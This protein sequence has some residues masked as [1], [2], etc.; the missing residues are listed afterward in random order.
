MMPTRVRSAGLEDEVD[1]LRVGAVNIYRIPDIAHIAWP[2]QALFVSLAGDKLAQAAKR[3][4][5]GM[6]D[7]SSGALILSFNVYLIETPEVVVL[8]DAGIGNDKERLDRPAWH[9]RSGRFLETLH[10]LGFAPDRIDL[11]VNTHLHA[12]H[13]GWNTVLADGIWRPTFPRARYVTSDVELAHWRG[14]HDADPSK[15][16][17][18][19]SFAD[20]VLPLIEAGRL[21]AVPSSTALAPGLSLAPVP[22]HSPGMVA[23][24]LTTPEAEILFLADAIHHPVQ[25]AD[26]ALCSNFCFD[27]ARA[28]ATR[29]R[30]LAECA[31]RAIVVA[32]YHF[33]SPAFG[34]FRMEGGGYEFVPLA[35]A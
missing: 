14:L 27:P 1:R 23:V 22:G 31:E 4:P 11:V 8:V 10:A 15:R 6:I 28:A 16:I 32:P 18:H 5:P 30:L 35:P 33:P 24:R 34:R 9:R 25:L 29:A 7:M 13:V 3:V 17:L 19:G 12:D 26:A 20:S 21:E 2:A